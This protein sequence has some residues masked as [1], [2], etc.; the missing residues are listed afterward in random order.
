MRT[1]LN[2]LLGGGLLLSLMAGAC[3]TIGVDVCEDAHPHI[4]KLAVSYTWPEEMSTGKTPN[5]CWIIANRPA[6]PL[7]YLFGWFPTE[8]ASFY[9][10]EMA[11]LNYDTTETKKAYFDADSIK[12]FENKATLYDALDHCGVR[13]GDYQM[14]TTNCAY[15]YEI[16]S[17]E[18]FFH[19]HEIFPKDLYVR[20]NT[21]TVPDSIDPALRDWMDFNPQYPF[22]KDIGPVFFDQQL[23]S[24]VRGQSTEVH[25]SPKVISQKIDLK[26]TIASQNEEVVIDSIRGE[27]SGVV[28]SK[29][30]FKGFLNMDGT[31][32]CRMI[33]STQVPID[34]LQG[35]NT[36]VWS[37]NTSLN[38][39]GLCEPANEKMQTGPGIVHLAAYV[40]YYKPADPVKGT[41]ERLVKRTIFWGINLYQALKKNPV[42]KQTED[43]YHHVISSSHETIVIPNILKI[44]L[45]DFDDDKHIE[46][47]PSDPNGGNGDFDIEF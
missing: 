14:L 40:H 15:Y 7:R 11:Y 46:I 37:C 31:Q 24:A 43:L 26:F 5:K 16:D 13:L 18:Q 44:D 6:D 21:E 8:T 34:T 19:N 10:R 42:T 47:W 4:S 12:W 35:T 23:V 20:Y 45:K 28:R 25:F 2:Y 41:P 33:F 3:D 27:I 22:V 32:S 29:S 39:L 36:R 9:G 38:V 17:L 30:L 1:R